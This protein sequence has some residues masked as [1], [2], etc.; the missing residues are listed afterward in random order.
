MTDNNMKI[1]DAVESTPQEFTKDARKGMHSF[2]SI[3]PGYL[4]KKATEQFGPYGKGFGLKDSKF[5][6][7]MFEATG[8]VIHE[9]VFFF[10]IEGEEST[11]QISNSMYVKYTSKK[12]QGIIVEEFAKKIET[13]TLSKAFSRLGI[14]GDVFMGMHDDQEYLNESYIENEYRKIEEGPGKV[15][16]LT[17]EFKEW[18]TKQCDLID[19]AHS[20]P[21]AKGCYTIAMNESIRKAK[22]LNMSEDRATQRIEQTFRERIKELKPSKIENINQDVDMNTGEVTND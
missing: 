7:E 14:G 8:M 5:N 3:S 2:K 22:T 18:I 17:E 16:E 10:M 1:W 20:I 19:K 13:N 9:A 12:G 15:T 21:L 11:F 6:W 4:M